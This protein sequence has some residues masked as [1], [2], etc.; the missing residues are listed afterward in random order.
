MQNST[1]TTV[2]KTAASAVHFQLWVSLRM[3]SRVV[4]Q[5]QCIRE[6]SM[7]EP[8]V[9]QVHPWSKNRAFSSS[10]LSM[11]TKLPCAR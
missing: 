3:V 7:V 6:K 4:E 10:R 11:D 2:G 1:P 9:I 5:G 8:A